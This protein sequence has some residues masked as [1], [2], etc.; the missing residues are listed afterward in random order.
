MWLIDFKKK[1]EK[2]QDHLV[3]ILYALLNNAFSS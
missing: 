2:E 3:Y 1:K